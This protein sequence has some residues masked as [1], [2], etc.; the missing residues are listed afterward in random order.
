MSNE[1][2][3][4]HW[5]EGWLMSVLDKDKLF[6]IM[7][8]DYMLNADEYDRFM[9]GVARMRS[10]EPLAYLVGEQDF[11]GRT[12]KV[13]PSTLIPRPD[14]ER[15][16]EAVL[17]WLSAQ[18]IDSPSILD[19]G[20]GSGCIAITLAKEL[21]TSD[22][23]AVDMSVDALAVAT[24]NGQR[25]AADNC[26]FVQSNWF[27]AVQGEFDIIVSNPP[28]IDKADKHLNALHHEPMTALVADD[29]G[30]SDIMMIIGG[31]VEYLKL[32]GLLAIEHGY[33]QGQSVRELFIRQGFDDVQTIKDYGGNDR[34][35]MGAWHG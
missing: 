23:L 21:P 24:Q 9:Q 32:G 27:D 4:Y 30:L 34:L 6:L 28:Y 3:P 20:T 19:L 7:H 14:T 2:F 17:D 31:S 29:L 13:N 8:D 18:T 5:L 22:V 25:L 10:G 1:A 16:I 11:F 12:F 33:D 35:T 15:L 26:R